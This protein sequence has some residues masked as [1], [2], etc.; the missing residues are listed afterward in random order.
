MVRPLTSRDVGT[1][2]HLGQPFRGIPLAWE[3]G[4]PA[5]GEDNEY[6]FKELLGLS[7][8]EYER[9]VADWV[10]AEDYLGADGNP[11]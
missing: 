8:A 2:D 4:A 3:R 9:L 11:Y 1:F 5:L 6:V 7:D 10:A